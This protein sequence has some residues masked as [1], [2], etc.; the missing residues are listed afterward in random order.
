MLQTLLSIDYHVLEHNINTTIL[1]AN[2]AG[3]TDIKNEK[4]KQLF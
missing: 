1:N 4:T 3:S 2:N